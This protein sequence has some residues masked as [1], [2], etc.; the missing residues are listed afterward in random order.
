M[1]DHPLKKAVFA[2]KQT[3]TFPSALNYG[4]TGIEFSG[5]V[6]GQTLNGSGKFDPRILSGSP[7]AECQISS[8]TALFT[9]H[10]DSTSARFIRRFLATPDRIQQ[11]IH[12]FRDTQNFRGRPI[13]TTP[14]HFYH[15]RP[16]F[17][18]FSVESFSADAVVLRHYCFNIDVDAHIYCQRRRY[19]PW[20][21][22]SGDIRLMPIFV[23]VRC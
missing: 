6:D 23:G 2:R 9:S 16:I 21:V 11:M 1:C 17:D 13:G 12:V 22:V 19:S 7:G 14:P 5:Q 10:G 8:K 15:Y 18:P 3:L 20:S 4:L